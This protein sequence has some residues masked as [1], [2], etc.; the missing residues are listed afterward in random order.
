M[1]STSETRFDKLFGGVPRA[2]PIDPRFAG[3]LPDRISV[4][5][6][7]DFS[8][9]IYATPNGRQTIIELMSRPL[10]VPTAVDGYGCLT[11]D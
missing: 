10:L 3:V 11:T 9:N 7:A 5:E 4:P 8:P 1:F 6:A 2:V